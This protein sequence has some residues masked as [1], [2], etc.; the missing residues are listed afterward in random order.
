VGVGALTDVE[1]DHVVIVAELA[2]FQRVV[3]IE[4][5]VERLADQV[6]RTKSDVI[7]MASCGTY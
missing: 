3:V 7:L 5:V 2:F 4:I 6:L 1:M